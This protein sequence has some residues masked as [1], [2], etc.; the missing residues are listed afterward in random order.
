MLGI[1]NIHIL[2]KHKGGRQGV[3]QMLT[4]AHNLEK[5]CWIICIISQIW[6]KTL[7]KAEIGNSLYENQRHKYLITCGWNILNFLWNF[8]LCMLKEDRYDCE[9]R[10]HSLFSWVKEF[11]I[12]RLA[13]YFKATRFQ[14]TLGWITFKYRIWYTITD[15]LWKGNLIFIYCDILRIHKLISCV[16]ARNIKV[17]IA[18]KRLAHDCRTTA[19]WLPIYCLINFWHFPD[20]MSGQVWIL[21]SKNLLKLNLLSFLKP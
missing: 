19:W 2:R 11:L 1:G 17:F 9:E 5:K 8:S 6:T 14:V 15:C 21:P 10:C 16:N 18:A 7:P 13:S 12:S 20:V 4:F 3:C